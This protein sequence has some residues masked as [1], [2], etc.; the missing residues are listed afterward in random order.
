[1]TESVEI[2][3]R[4]FSKPSDFVVVLI[5]A[6]EAIAA[7][8]TY[9]SKNIETSSMQLP[10]FEGF[11]AAFQ[12]LE[13]AMSLRASR[14]NLAEVDFKN[15]QRLILTAFIKDGQVVDLLAKV[16]EQ[17]FEFFRGLAYSRFAR[18]FF[19]LY[20]RITNF[21][22]TLLSFDV[23]DLIVEYRF[24]SLYAHF[25]FMERL[26]ETSFEMI[27]LKQRSTVTEEIGFNQEIFEEL[28]QKL[29]VQVFDQ[30]LKVSHFLILYTY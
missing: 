14:Q 18:A 17:F 24:H 11:F 23:H 15:V 16:C 29:K 12:I 30:C 19:M 13:I 3:R 22:Q 9:K 1:M 6:N 10:I 4:N 25:S 26:L 2:T 27:K 8:E 7:Y 21:N 5:A 20:M 28:F